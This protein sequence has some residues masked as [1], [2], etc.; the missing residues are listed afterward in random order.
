M[1]VGKFILQSKSLPESNFKCSLLAEN[2]SNFFASNTLTNNW[3]IINLNQ[4]VF[5]NHI[6]EQL[7]N[8]APNITHALTPFTPNNQLDSNNNRG[9]SV[10]HDVK[11]NSISLFPACMTGLPENLDCQGPSCKAQRLQEVELTFQFESTKIQA[12]EKETV[13]LNGGS[14][15]KPWLQTELTLLFYCHTFWKCSHKLYCIASLT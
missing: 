13:N 4:F 10:K 5:C 3:F 8:H 15:N 6:K 9:N 11:Q 12:F 14:L 7:S 1:R 2:K